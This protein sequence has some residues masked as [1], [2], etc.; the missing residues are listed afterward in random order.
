MSEQKKSSRI[1]DLNSATA[2]MFGI[3]PCPRCG[4][5]YRWQHAQTMLIICDGCRLTEEEETL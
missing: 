1:I 5:K 2:N 4:S 3:E